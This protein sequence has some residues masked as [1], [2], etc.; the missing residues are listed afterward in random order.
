MCGVRRGSMAG[1]SRPR[2]GSERR[3]KPLVKALREITRGTINGGAGSVDHQRHSR[4]PAPDDES[5]GHDLDAWV[6]IGDAA[7]PPHSR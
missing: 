3:R 7:G 1:G 4:R 2:S 5:P 6:G